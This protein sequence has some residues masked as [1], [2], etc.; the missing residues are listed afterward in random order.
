MKYEQ[1]KNCEYRDE[2]TH[3]CDLCIEQKGD[4]L[5]KQTEQLLRENENI[6]D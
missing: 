2:I 1:C 3:I 4:L 5:R 6:M